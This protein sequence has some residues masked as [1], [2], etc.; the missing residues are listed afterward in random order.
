MPLW[1][2]GHGLSYTNFTYSDL[3][4]APQNLK[5]YEPLQLYVTVTN[6]GPRDGKEV[7][8]VHISDVVSS[9]V[10]AVQQLVGFEKVSLKCV[11]VSISIDLFFFFVKFI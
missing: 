11:C 4:L 10:T 3:K 9:V 1:S 7:V 2:F 5:K 8:Q 6:N